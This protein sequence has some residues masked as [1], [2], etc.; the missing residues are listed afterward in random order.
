[1]DRLLASQNI[2]NCSVRWYNRSETVSASNHSH[3]S[4]LDV[5]CKWRSAPASRVPVALLITRKYPRVSSLLDFPLREF[6]S[7][8]RPEVLATHVS[9]TLP[10]ISFTINDWSRNR[11]RAELSPDAINVNIC[12]LYRA[13]S[14]RIYSRHG[15]GRAT[16]PSSLTAPFESLSIDL[17]DHNSANY[18]DCQIVKLFYMNTSELLS[19]CLWSPPKRKGI[20]WVEDEQEYTCKMADGVPNIRLNGSL[21]VRNSHGCWSFE[22]KCSC[23]SAVSY[24]NSKNGRNLNFCRTEYGGCGRFAVTIYLP[25]NY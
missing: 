6:P 25:S 10:S 2:L 8:V 14:S 13:L 17:T 4:S 16:N 15:Q 23:C 11:Q 22:I 19:P 9:A 7:L 24:L 1:M 3:E 20:Q 18:Y 5:D 12:K 21:P